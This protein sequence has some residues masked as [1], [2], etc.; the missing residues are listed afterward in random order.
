MMLECGLLCGLVR[1]PEKFHCSVNLIVKFQ[2]FFIFPLILH[3][4]IKLLMF[5]L[6]YWYTI[7]PHR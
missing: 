7:I 3:K 6:Q 5:V 1:I 2:A 4:A